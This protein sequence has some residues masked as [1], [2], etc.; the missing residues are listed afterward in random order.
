MSAHGIARRWGRTASD[1]RRAR[2][3]GTRGKT[4]SNARKDNPWT[5]Q[6]ARAAFSIFLRLVD[7]RGL[8]LWTRCTP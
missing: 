4:V 3:S 1:H 7:T 5:R 8:A 6:T 2:Q